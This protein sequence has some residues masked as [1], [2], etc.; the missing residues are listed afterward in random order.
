M[1]SPD[2]NTTEV[3]SM[4][5]RTQVVR[6][7][8]KESIQD[9]Y[10]DDVVSVSPEAL[11]GE[12]ISLMRE[13]AISCIVVTDNKK[14][15]GILTE[16]DIVRC[17]AEF[18]TGFMERP[19]GE[20]HTKHVFTVNQRS[21]IIEAFQLLADN[22]IRHIVV[23]DDK[24]NAA[25]VATQSDLLEHLGYEY[26]VRVKTVDQVMSRQVFTTSEDAVLMDATREMAEH[27]VS[28]LI[29]CDDNRPIGVLTERD[30]A[31]LAAD[32]GIAWDSRV[33]AVMSTPVYTAHKDDSAYDASQRM[34]AKKIRRLVVVDDHGKTIGVITQ[35]DMIRGLESQYI[36]TMKT[37][38][39]QQGQ[40]L[41]R[42]IQRL[43]EKTLYLDSI[44]SSSIDMGIIATDADL[45]IVYYN[46]AAEAILGVPACRALHRNI[47]DIHEAESIDAERLR[48]AL[49]VIH[50]KRF[51]TFQF[52]RQRDG[53]AMHV[54]GRLSSINGQ[55]N[56]DLIGYVLMLQDV[57]E[58]HNAEETIRNLAFYD[59][60][61]GLPNRALFYER[62]YTEIARSRRNDSRFC[63]MIM[64]IDQFKKINDTYGHHTGDSVLKEVGRRLAMLLR[65]TD[66]A[67]RL[68]GDEFAFILPD[69][70]EQS[71]MMHLANKILSALDKPVV[72]NSHTL[73]VHYS[74]G[75][76]VFPDHGV[77]AES[78]YICSDEA[79][80][81]AKDLGRG[82]DR[83][84]V[85]LA[86]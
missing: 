76:G 39:R 2:L 35:T 42:V 33:N 66:T 60:L 12:A 30:V 29:V 85:I 4:H 31:H 37:I 63:L 21:H 69:V 38:I 11:M 81:K 65:G 1:R 64:D 86:G 47:R 45:K 24:G 54:H 79:M 72:V 70:E 23:V 41:D 78:L 48:H 56:G 44:L 75:I 50:E 53:Q 84:N 67:A 62:L 57:T 59:M 58:Q 71:V 55:H 77:D 73:H 22:Q 3:G 51:H 74:L 83:S 36:D 43:S 82:N 7:M 9:I 80:Y 15:V 49:Q 27:S 17:I 16:R 13:H 14:P 32:R 25:G 5:S 28:F 19:I 18:G 61:T 26:F 68:G 6:S 46:P 20:L 8:L 34:R 40:E 10:C 52:T